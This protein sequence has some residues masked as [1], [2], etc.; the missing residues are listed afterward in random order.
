MASPLRLIIR[1]G[2]AE[3]NSVHLIVG[4]SVKPT[5]YTAVVRAKN[6]AASAHDPDMTG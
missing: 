3:T 5:G 6:P 4:R 2:N 1:H